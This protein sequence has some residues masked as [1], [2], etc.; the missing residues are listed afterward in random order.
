MESDMVILILN[1]SY[2]SLERTNKNQLNHLETRT[3][4]KFKKI[5]SSLTGYIIHQK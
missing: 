2:E 1:L 5:C 4:N 3:K